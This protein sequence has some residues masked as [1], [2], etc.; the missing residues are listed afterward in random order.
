MVRRVRKE[1]YYQRWRREHPELRLYLSR[2]EYN[3]I[4]SLADREGVSMKEVVLNAVKGLYSGDYITAGLDIAVK[5]LRE[6]G[7]HFEEYAGGYVNG[8][9]VDGKLSNPIVF[10]EFVGRVYGKEVEEGS[11]LFKKFEELHKAIG[12]IESKGEDRAFQIF[13]YDPRWFYELAWDMFYYRE[14]FEG[15]VFAAPCSVC[16]RRLIFTHKDSSWEKVKPILIEAFRG[17]RHND[18]KKPVDEAEPTP[19]P[20]LKTQPNTT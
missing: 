18:C 16:G 17:W 1:R 8:E 6:Y 15:A 3:F 10:K 12:F 20:T 13:I 11:P 9:Y 19:P 7:E 2:D 4:K 5:F 14:D